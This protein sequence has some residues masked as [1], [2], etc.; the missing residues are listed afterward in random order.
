MKRALV[1]LALAASL[2]GCQSEGTLLLVVLRSDYPIPDKLRSMDVVVRDN[3]TD[4][5]LAEESFQLRH[6]VDLPLSFTIAP[7]RE[8]LAKKVK[9][10]VAALSPSG[11]ILSDRRTIVGFVKDETRLLDLIIAARCESSSCA[12]GLACDEVGCSAEE[13][14]VNSLPIVEHGKEL[15]PDAGLS[16]IS[17]DT[18]VAA[19]DAE[20]ADAAEPDA[21][22][23]D[24]AELDGAEPDAAAPDAAAMDAE[25][26]DAAPDAGV[27]VDT[28]V[29]PDSGVGA[30][31]GF[32]ANCNPACGGGTVCTNVSTG[33]RCYAPTRRVSAEPSATRSTVA[34]PA[35]PPGRCA[36][37]STGRTSMLARACLRAPASGLARA[38]TSPS[39][40]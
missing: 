25:P 20:P 35:P 26:E 19:S 15:D 29:I 33:L 11:D 30:D 8:F 13:I 39:T 38:V 36:V 18:G 21:A 37:G 17:A 5:I 14:D 40:G 16:R 7:E 27:P 9:L 28:G 1:G 23:P 31:A 32:D 22:V 10:D 24:A 2:C 34:P 3:D 6:H 4:R 12:D